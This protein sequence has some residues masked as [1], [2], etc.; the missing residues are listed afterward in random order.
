MV[1]RLYPIYA[2]MLR[3]GWTQVCEQCGYFG[4]PRDPPRDF[5]TRTCTATRPHQRSHPNSDKDV[6]CDPECR[7]R[8]DYVRRDGICGPEVTVQSTAKEQQRELEYDGKALHDDVEAPLSHPFRPTQDSANDSFG[9][10]TSPQIPRSGGLLSFPHI[11]L[12]S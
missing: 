12:S 2:W 8:E 3:P 11:Q 6:K 4:I 10:L 9:G 1:S 7:N 5:G